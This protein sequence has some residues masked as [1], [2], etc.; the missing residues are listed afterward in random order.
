[1]K[2]VLRL[3][4]CAFNL[5]VCV[6]LALAQLKPNQGPARG[7]FYSATIRG[8]RSN[9]AIA[10]KGLVVTLGEDKQ[11]WVCYDTDLM[12]VSMLW[13]GEFLEFGN[14]LTSIA[15]PP[16]PQVKGTPVFSTK[17]GPGWAA[18]ESLEDPR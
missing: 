7:P 18:G 8:P 16:P 1:M 11:T 6:S 10:M 5:T 12:R 14:T 3:A 17:A 9:E 4:V 2:F 15:W 13:R